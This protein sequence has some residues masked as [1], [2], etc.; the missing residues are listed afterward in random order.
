MS[1][2]PS[3]KGRKVISIYVNPEVLRSFKEA[4]DKAGVIY[5]DYLENTLKRL[6]NILKR[7][8]KN[9]NKSS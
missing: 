2:L 8:V 1:R 5:G 9:E 4:C 7:R 6:T 3:R